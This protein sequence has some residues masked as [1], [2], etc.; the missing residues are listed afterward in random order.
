MKK[1]MMY[2]FLIVITL[3]MLSGCFNKEED[4]TFSNV[5]NNEIG[6]YKQSIF[7]SEYS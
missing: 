5:Q 2:V 1:K 4:N 6:N 3:F 7:N